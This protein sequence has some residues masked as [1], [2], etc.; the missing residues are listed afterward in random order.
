LFVVLHNLKT[1]VPP[2]FAIQVGSVVET[3]GAK[4]QP[5]S[6]LAKYFF[7]KTL[8]FSYYQTIIL[9]KHFLFLP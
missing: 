6:I 8:Y 5:F 7:T 9:K 1:K 4:I 3:D 2:W